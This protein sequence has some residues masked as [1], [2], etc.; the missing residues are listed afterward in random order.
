LKT[1]IKRFL[2]E[3]LIY[4][5]LIG[6]G[7][8]FAYDY[9]APTYVDNEQTITVD[10]KSLL[11]FM[12]QKTKAVDQS[13]LI[14]AFEGLTP[15]KRQ[16]LIDAYVREEALFRESKAL[17]LHKGDPIIK[18]R[19]IQNLEFITQDYSE[20]I[21]KVTDEQLES[22]FEKNKQNYYVE[23]FVTF[24][25][26]FFDKESNGEDAAKNLAEEK[27]IE[28]NKNKVAFSEGL[29][30]GD[31]FPYHVNYVERTPDFIASHFGQPMAD[32]VFTIPYS[33]ATSDTQTWQ[34]PFE[35]PY[36][37]HLVML[38]RREEGKTPALLDVA[39]QVYQDAQRT[40]IREN[41]DK[42]YQA[43]IN[44]Y[45]VEISAD[46]NVR[47]IKAEQFVSLGSK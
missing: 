34:G 25:H 40:Q 15:N 9:F 41:L 37:Y 1:Q 3:P 31:R 10:K 35:S 22:Y 27:L 20:A 46:L 36:G 21:I 17:G 23:P 30:H 42:T 44:T 39:G 47:T 28:L 13:K 5:L 24:T 11:R 45:S 33:N 14:S 43:I 19:A 8:F 2:K 26:V 38:S 29:Q 18:N 16:K 32:D 6:G 4:F 12:Q 7:F